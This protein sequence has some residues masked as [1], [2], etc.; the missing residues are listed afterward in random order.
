MP[1]QAAAVR[2]WLRGQ[3]LAAERI[4]EERRVAGP[5]PELAVA[6]ARSAANAL[7]KMGIWPGPRD[8]GS[9]SGVLE[10]RRRWVRI[11]TKAKQARQRR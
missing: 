6:E 2:R 5:Q 9:E 3:E 8:P 10:M 11:Q 7:A 1:D 4:V